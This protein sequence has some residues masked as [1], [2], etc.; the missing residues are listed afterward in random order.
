MN[1]QSR[2][3]CAVILAAGDGK[4]MK[5]DRPKALC[6]V[7]FK[8]MLKWVEDACRAAGID[9]IWVVAGANAEL[10]EAAAPACRFVCQ[11]ERRGTGHAAMMAAEAYRAGGDV[12]VLNGDAP[13]VEP[14]ALRDALAM[15]RAGKNAVTL[16][17][18]RLDDP[19]GYGRVIRGKGGAVAAVVEEKDADEAQRAVCEINSGA[20]WFDAAFLA[21]A[22]KGLTPK[23]AQGEYY[24]TDTVAASNAAGLRAGAFICADADMTLGANDRRQLRTL[25]EIARMRV[26]ERHL[27]N[28]VDIPC[29]DG[30]MIAPDVQIEHDAQVLPGTVLRGNT[31]IGAHSVIGPNSYVENSVVGANTRVLAS[32]VTDSTVGSGTRI[33]PFTQLRPDSHIGDGVKIGDFVEIKNSTIGDRT[34]LA[35]LTYIGDSDVGC[36]CN[37]GCGVVTANYDGNHKFRTVVGDRAFIGCNTNLVP[38][39]RV[40]TGAYTA[41]GTTVDA[42]VPDGALAIGRVRQQIKEGWSD[43]N[44]NFKGG[45]K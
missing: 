19:F 17:S 36:D 13:F 25:N 40:G 24:L 42:D 12:L 21:K 20:Y 22:L 26:L 2:R 3:V 1:E 43:R 18:A 5:S 16:L 28:G 35:H 27:D 31:R 37:F 4:R 7:L 38:P 41:A 8:P 30:V 29:F 44:I 14:Q 23:N 34:S 39:V 45:K 10:L 32:Y 9:E 33:G 15:H 11:T 6:E